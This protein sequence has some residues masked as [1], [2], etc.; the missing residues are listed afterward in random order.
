MSISGEDLP[1][2]AR[3]LTF[4]WEAG[5]QLGIDPDSVARRARRLGWSSLQNLQMP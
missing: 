4:E 3:W 1:P 5:Q 2:D